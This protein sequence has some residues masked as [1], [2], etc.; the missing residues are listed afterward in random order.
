MRL[1]HRSFPIAV[2]VVT[3]VGLVPPV[4]A[5]TASAA[6]RVILDGGHID[7]V[8]IGLEAGKLRMQVSDDSGDTVRELDPA[9]VV[10]HALPAAETEIP[11][12][13]EYAFLGPAGSTTWLL[14]E[15]QN[16]DVVWPGYNTYGI[17]PGQVRGDEVTLRLLDVRGPGSLSLFLSGPSGEPI[18]LATT[19]RGTPYSVPTTVSAMSPPQPTVPIDAHAHMNWAFSKPGSYDV[20][21]QADAVRADGTAVSTGP[22]RYRFVMGALPRPV[23]ARTAGLLASYPAGSRVSLT[24]SAA[25]AVSGATWTWT[26]ECPG[27][28]PVR[29]GS[30]AATIGFTAEPALNGCTVTARVFDGFGVFQAQTSPAALTVT[31]AESVPGPVVDPTT[32]ASPGS[33]TTPPSAAPPPAAGPGATPPPAAA[34]GAG[35]RLLKPVRIDGTRRSGGRVT[36]VAS[37]SGASS[38]RYSWTRD[39]KALPVNRPSWLLRRVDAGHRIACSAMA[40]AP[41]GARTTAATSFVP[42]PVQIRA[43]VRPAALGF[44]R[45][46]VVLRAEPGRWSPTATG[47][48]YQWLR[49]G[50][51]IP[52]AVGRSHLL[53]AADD[54]HRISVRVTALRRGSDAAAAVSKARLIR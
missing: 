46:G 43:A 9:D 1:A 31:S 39:G 49:S 6:D 54:G 26:R 29:V 17:R 8:A 16:P 53:R 27:A 41:S 15:V 38:V 21:F 18:M 11:D 22:V 33:P 35:P 20:T 36:C 52:G 34:P 14:P 5:P 47:H 28:T 2:A 7:V 4:L 44:P 3:A 48:R 23:S 19:L 40:I 50:R 37:F 30:S 42:R 32:P 51:P 10:I 24:A 13:P 45:V 12:I 25:P